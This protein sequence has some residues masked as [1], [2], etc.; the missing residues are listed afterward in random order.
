[1]TEPQ[2]APDLPPTTRRRGAARVPEQG[3]GALRTTR[4]DDASPFHSKALVAFATGLWPDEMDQRYT[5]FPTLDSRW[6]RLAA[7]VHPDCIFCA[8]ASSAAPA[9]VVYE[10]AFSIAFLDLR[11]FH[12]GHT[13]LIPR[14]HVSDVRD[15]DETTGA[16]LIAALSRVTRAVTAA[17]PGQG[18]SVWHSIG[19]AAFQEVPHLHFHIHPRRMGDDVLRVYPSTPPTPGRSELDAYAVAIRRQLATNQG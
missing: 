18:T 9:S 4:Q 14:R 8:I 15:L 13:L 17:F 10:D 11:Q 6:H 19:A 16:Q 2:A 7:P 12:P 1:M 5:S 3:T